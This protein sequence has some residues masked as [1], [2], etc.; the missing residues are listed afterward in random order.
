MPTIIL[1]GDSHDPI[2]VRAIM[3]FPNDD[4]LRNLYFVVD[5]IRNIV[6]KAKDDSKLI[7]VEAGDLRI[8]VEGPDLARLDM[9]SIEA[10]RSGIVAGDILATLYLMDRFS[11]EEPSLK[12][13]VYVAHEFA[14]MER[15]GDGKRM[16]TSP[17]KIRACWQDFMSVA[18]LWAAFRL[19]QAYPYTS[20]RTDFSSGFQSLLEVAAELL[21]FGFKFTPLR[22][23]STVLDCLQ[24]WTLPEAVPPK[25]LRTNRLP[26]LL[27]KVLKN[28]KASYRAAY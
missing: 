18:H 16:N 1:N 26:D 28:Y 6:S 10:I 15:Y 13:A 7:K 3:H 5:K 20:N 14:K 4:G 17:K 2:R 21:R 27:I 11:L 23:K 25:V 19:N 9:A 12:K 8:L 22:S 24:S